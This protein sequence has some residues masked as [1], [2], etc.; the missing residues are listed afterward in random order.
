MAFSVLAF[1][2]LVPRGRRRRLAFGAALGFGG[3]VGLA[4][5]AQG[6]H[7]LSDT[8]FA[9]LFMALLA[10]LLHRWIVARDG[11]A[12]PWLRRGVTAAG[13]LA[14]TAGRRIAPSSTHPLGRFPPPTPPPPP[15]LTLSVPSLHPPLPPS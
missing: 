7:F 8:I 6:G 10:W 13:R 3:F 14:R 2:F 4:R 12:A 11:L 1:G 5:I 9:A 15:P